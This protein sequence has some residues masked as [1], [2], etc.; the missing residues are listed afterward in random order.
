MTVLQV[1]FETRGTVELKRTGVYPYAK[2]HDTRVWLMAWAFDDEEP[3]VW[4]PDR[5]LLPARV[6]DHI[7]AHGE[8]R[9]WNAQFERLMWRDCLPR[10]VPGIIVPT[11][12]QWYCTEADAM[13]M[14]LPRRLD[15]CATVLGIPEKKD[16]EGNKLMLRMCRPRK[17]DKETA[18]PI[19]WVDA[20]KL[21]RLGEYCKQDVRTERSIAKRTRRLSSFE[22]QV[23]LRN[24]RMNDRGLMMDRPLVAALSALAEKEMIKQNAALVD[25]TEGAVEK[26]T[27][28]ARLKGWLEAQGLSM[29]SL[30]K[31]ILDELLAPGMNMAD[32]VRAALEAR[33]ESNKSSL[34]KLQ[35]MLDCADPG[36]D[37]MRGLVIYHGASTGR[38][39]GKLVQPHNFVRPTLSQEEI[40][41]A[42]P[43]VLAGNVDAIPRPQGLLQSYA[44]LLR[45]CI[46]A[47]GAKEFYCVDFAGIEARVVA[48]LAGD[49]TYLKI[50]REGKKVYAEMASHIFKKPAKDIVK[51]SPEYQLGKAAI[52]GCGFGMG[53]EKFCKTAGVSEAEGAL[54]VNGFRET[55]A[56]VPELWWGLDNA[57]KRAIKRPGEVQSFRD[58]K[59][60]VDSGYLWCTLPSKRSLAYYKPLIEDKMTPWGELKP[61]ITFMGYSS[62]THQWERQK[63]YG[64]SLTENV[65]QAVARD[66]LV[67]AEKR[68][69]EEGFQV[70]LK[71]H[72]EIVAE[73][74]AGI[75]VF[76]DFLALM[77]TPPSWGR[78]CPIDAEG[79]HGTR[80][81]K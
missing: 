51:G 12:E 37:R 14:A 68:V 11:L 31:K 21:A 57:A 19:W 20:E 71:V 48:W 75:G 18:E 73:V 33:R 17:F 72:D 16:M 66:L 43:N 39:A 36:D 41:K 79:W 4:Y 28:V 29:D 23:Y 40:D 22:R 1:D 47:G 70:V 56:Q 50:F 27:Q 81:R 58:I 55:F 26:T 62:F 6:F 77:K 2:H 46:I 42:I 24:Q 3:A 63:T 52:L 34:A 45:S 15:M 32:D 65:V 74:P 38:E 80:Y 64:G 69:D 67:E 44:S 35:S 7:A 9:A 60:V 30:G 13:A 5:E 25:A 78:D 53:V 8:M 59:Y 10:M 76:D 49:P 54:A 61:S